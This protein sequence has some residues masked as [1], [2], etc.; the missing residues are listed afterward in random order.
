MLSI[1]LMSGT[2]MDG[3]DVALLKTDGSPQLIE[4][5]AHTSISY[6][7]PFKILLKAA[8]FCIRDCAGNIQAANQ[9]FPIALKNYLIHELKLS[10]EVAL[11]QLN[12]LLVYM[13]GKNYFHHTVSLEDVIR[14]S[15]E[16]H[17]FA[18]KKL[19]TE[20][21]MASTQIDVVG[22]H[23]QTLLHQ[24]E[25]KM[26]VVVGNGKYLAEDLGIVVVNDFRAR[27]IASGGLG[28][29][30]APLYHYALAVR[31]NK[32]PC[33]VVNCGGIANLTYIPNA[34]EQDILGFD[35]G[36][37][38]GLIDRWVRMYTQ[39]KENMDKDGKYGQCGQVQEKLL[40]ALYDKA[41]VKEGRNGLLQK[42]PNSLDYG[43][44]TLISELS[45]YAFEDACATLEAFTADTI[46]QSFAKL[47]VPFP[48][49]W[50]LAGGGWNNPVITEQL[51]TRLKQHQ[52][53]V[54]VQKADD[55]GWSSVAMEAQIFAYFAVRSLRN[56]PL[57]MPNTTKVRAPL[58][59]GHAHI[60]ATGA[61]ALVAALLQ[62][63][64]FVLNGYQ[65]T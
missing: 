36:P 39:G 3:I 17:G 64:P 13:Y 41:I 9:Q 30:F 23:G 22:Y 60:P 26:S 47:G 5:L 62:E 27:D 7:S 35:T 28:A 2:S 51:K 16:L 4:A 44:L 31:D 61:T 57:S 21:G 65:F 12:E 34:N 40:K 55:I 48:R 46:V 59:G 45:D 29:P 53:N 56:L 32:T 38:N 14:H 52:S 6:D 58:S 10:E 63:N 19:L 54:N 43:D 24:P 42:G 49:E 8:E 11:K 18:V 15:T 33:V 1:G 20:T 50:I 37:G 25:K